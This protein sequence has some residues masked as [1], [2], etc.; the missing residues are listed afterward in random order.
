MAK[1]SL[2]ESVPR[3]S[4]VDTKVTLIVYL[5]SLVDIS[6]SLPREVSNR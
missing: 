5:D 6:A 4:I 1:V 3:D 2:L